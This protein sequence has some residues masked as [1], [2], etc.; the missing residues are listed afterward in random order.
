MEIGKGRRIL[1]G[2]L[3]AITLVLCWRSL[4]SIVAVHSGVLGISMSYETRR[5]HEFIISDTLGHK[6]V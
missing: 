4:V 2:I 1:G 6:A 5:Y 3:S